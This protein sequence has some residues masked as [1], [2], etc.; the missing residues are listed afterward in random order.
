[1]RHFLAETAIIAVILAAGSACGAPLS[2]K[3]C[4][5]K[6]KRSNPLLKTVR[7]DKELAAT[8]IRQSDASLYPRLDIHG[9]YTVQQAPQGVVLNGRN[10]D[11]QQSEFAY[12]NAAI[13]Y[14]IYDFGRRDARGRTARANA[15]AID[16]SVAAREKDVSLQIISAYFG[17]LEAQQLVKAAEEEVAQVGEHRRIA[18]I[19]HQ[20][21]MVTRNDVLQ[22]DVRLASARQK[23]LSEKNRLEN[24][25][26]QLNYLTGSPPITR[27]ELDANSDLAL[28]ADLNPDTKQS[29]TAR[30]ELVSL[31][32]SLDAS[33]AEVDESRRSFYPEL[34]TKLGLDYVQNDRV[35]EQTIL[36]ATVGLKM[37]LFDGFS[38]TSAQER[39]VLNRLKAEDNLRLAETEATL[40]LSTACNDARV[41]GERIGVT[42]TA[43]VQS[44][45][46]LR[47]NRDRYQ[48]R[49][50]TA[51]DVLDAQ[52]LLIQAKTEYFRALYDYQV[53]SARVR[54][55]MGSL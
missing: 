37:N 14:T 25:W 15:E 8:A 41:A 26:L 29:L 1:M 17:I 7:N 24:L 20:Q 28:P 3:E 4:L 43:I 2:L 27:G 46:N 48:A 10:S 30:P 32:K 12:A 39:A 21:G 34:F 38:T 18:E 42:K 54:R 33:S 19:L 51:T 23:L 35:T 13:T 49:V 5:E 45:E 22:A 53:A 9:G 40:E 36:S 31:R 11:T 47:I 16:Y 6:G 55:A 50:G 52:T 44:E